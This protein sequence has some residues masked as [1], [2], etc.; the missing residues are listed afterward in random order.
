[1]QRLIPCHGLGPAPFVLTVIAMVA[2]VAAPPSH[3]G[4]LPKGFVYLRDI[5]P[6]ILQDMRYAG[7]NNFVGKAVPGYDAPECVLVEEAAQAL[8]KAQAEVHES[9]LTL[10]VYDCYRPARAVKA[11]V[12]WAKLPDDAEAK[13]SYYPALEKRALFPD[14]IATISSHSRGAT[15]DLTLAPLDAPAAPTEATP[16]KPAPCTATG[17]PQAPDGSLDMGTS[18]DCFDVK[19]ETLAPGLGPKQRTN[20]EMLVEVM[21]R[22]GFKNYAREWWHYTLETEPYPATIFDFPI[23]KRDALPQEGAQP[24]KN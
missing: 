1:V 9:G 18:F 5:D 7:A 20:R 16:G 21:R 15:V 23:R 12:A 10:K 2:I 3:A 17:G 6:T 19:A 24:E 8:K 22:H 11:F 4:D 14:Y 13:A